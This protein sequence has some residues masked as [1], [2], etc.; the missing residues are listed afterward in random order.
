MQFE[1]DDEYNRF[2]KEIESNEF[3]FG[4]YMD[5]SIHKDSFSCFDIAKMHRTL[6]KKI[7]QY[8]HENH[9]NKLVVYSDF[10]VR[11]MTVEWARKNHVSEK[12]V[13]AYTVR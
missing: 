1:I 10:C 7:S 12:V 13:E 8:L 2:L 3:V 6:K 5:E 9:P 11:V 4:T